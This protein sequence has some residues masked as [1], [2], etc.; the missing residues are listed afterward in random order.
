MMPASVD[1]HVHSVRLF[2]WMGESLSFYCN[3]GGTE[4]K[5][6][7]VQPYTN[8]TFVLLFVYVHSVIWLVQKTASRDIDNISYMK[9][10]KAGQKISLLSSAFFQGDQKLFEVNYSANCNLVCCFCRAVSGCGC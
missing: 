3:Q 6:W 2:L 1:P 4:R 7:E 10:L 8:V 5:R 9:S